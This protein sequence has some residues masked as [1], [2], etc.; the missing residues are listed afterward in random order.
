MVQ[1]PSLLQTCCEGEPLRIWQGEP[2]HA[3]S[4]LNDVA[5]R[6]RPRPDNVNYCMR[7]SKLTFGDA[8]CKGG[9]GGASVY[10]Y[11]HIYIYARCCIPYASSCH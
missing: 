3:E 1:R 2:L 10:L 7:M 5:R 8:E 11:I 4:I 9:G 6:I